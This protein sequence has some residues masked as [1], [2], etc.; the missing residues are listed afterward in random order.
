MPCCPSTS[1][2]LI[3]ADVRATLSDPQS[4]T[5]TTRGP[6]NSSCYSLTGNVSRSDQIG[7]RPGPLPSAVC[8]RWIVVPPT[9]PFTSPHPQVPSTHPST[10]PSHH[11]TKAPLNNPPYHFSLPPVSSISFPQTSTTL[12]DFTVSP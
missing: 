6:L 11:T 2:T 1:H 8:P 12:N 3:S 5:S 9:R 10:S 4:C 7:G